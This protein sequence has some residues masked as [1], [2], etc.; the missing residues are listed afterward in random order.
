M[1]FCMAKKSMETF[2]KHRSPIISKSLRI[3]INMSYIHFNN[4]FTCFK[5]PSRLAPYSNPPPLPPMRG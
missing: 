5:C 1:S 4:I 2:S 3:Y